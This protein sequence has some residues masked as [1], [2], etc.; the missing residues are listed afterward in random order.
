MDNHLF[1]II[2]DSLVSF[3][4]SETFGSDLAKDD[5]ERL[6]VIIKLI[7]YYGEDKSVEIRDDRT[8]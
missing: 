8:F 5:T 7:K 1:I 2:T 4:E 6:K 3:Q